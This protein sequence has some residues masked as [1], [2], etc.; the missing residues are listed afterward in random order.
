[1]GEGS[2]NAGGGT[3]FYERRWFLGLAAVVGLVGAVAALVGP[4]KL[5]DV[6][7]DRFSSE[8]PA[9]NT[10]IVLD[11]SAGMG[12]PFGAS[13]TKL[14][15]AAD[16]V[17]EF[18]APFKNEGFAL[19]SFGGRCKGEGEAG[20]LLVDF[21]EDHGDD[22]RVA[23][24]EQRPNGK[25]NLA[26]AVIAA[27]DDFSDE[28]RFPDPDSPRR[29]V[30]FTGTVDEC[31]PDAA[32]AIRREVRHKGVNAVFR[33]VGVKVSTPDRERLLGF[34]E[35]LGQDFDVSVAFADSDEQLIG[36]LRSLVRNCADGAD[37][38]GDELVDDADPGCADGT[39]AD[40]E[41]AG[42]CADEMDND[43][44]ELVDDEDPGCADG[45]EADSSFVLARSP[46]SAAG[47][48]GGD[49]EAHRSSGTTCLSGVVA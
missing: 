46:P 32:D 38:D 36:V 18:V 43:G 9:Y 37:N 8:L 21:G 16:A 20:R 10:E 33:F 3:P 31:R 2:A 17:A 7:A 34:K 24:A 28:D 40:N 4:P 22:V 6:V 19:R 29:V 49:P 42:E 48:V 23:A 14:D 45:T 27:V 30:V 15:A 25:S 1:M 11:A 26:D 44:D 39:E 13:R 47:A 41:P 5:W 35:D 12:M